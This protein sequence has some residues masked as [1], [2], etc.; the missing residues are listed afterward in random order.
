MK[1][2]IKFFR[3]NKLQYAETYRE[4]IAV[5][6]FKGPRG[7]FYG[8]IKILVFKLANKLKIIDGLVN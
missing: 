6:N 3:K 7:L 4:P 2:V 8:M 1:L 5:T